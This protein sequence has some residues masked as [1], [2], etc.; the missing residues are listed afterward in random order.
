MT[1]S[2]GK[3]AEML[4]DRVGSFSFP[5]WQLKFAVKYFMAAAISAVS[6]AQEGDRNNLNDWQQADVRLRKAAE[7]LA[8]QIDEL[9]DSLP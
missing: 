8:G 5:A 3:E 2:A 9:L 6:E 7:A 1:V 4:A